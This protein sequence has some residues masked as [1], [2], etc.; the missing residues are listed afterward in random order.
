MLARH[1]VTRQ[2][3]LD[4]VDAYIV[5]RDYVLAHVVAQLHHSKL[6]DGISVLFKGGTALRLVYFDSYRYS[7]DLDFTVVGGT[8]EEAARRIGLAVDAAR[9]FAGFPILELASDNTHVAYIGPLG[10]ATARLV[11]LDISNEEVVDTVE[12]RVVMSRIWNDLPR[13][14]FVDVYSLEDISAEKLR[15]VMQRVQCRDLY[16]LYR[17]VSG[18]RIDLPM[19]LGLFERKARVKDLDPNDFRDVFGERVLRYRKLWTKELTGHLTNP[20]HFD[21]VVRVARRNLRSTGLI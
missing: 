3:T 7:A 15:C 14:Q 18:A 2:A 21:E 4:N 20:P 1:F 10:A 11:K 8:I 19:V 9:E 5:E 13:P 12:R 16:D 6:G 17:I